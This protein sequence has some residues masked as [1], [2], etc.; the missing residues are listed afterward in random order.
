MDPAFDPH[1]GE[2]IPG[3]TPSEHGS[4]PDH[5]D[6]YATALYVSGIDPKGKGRNERGP[7]TYIK[8]A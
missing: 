3:R 4:I 5:G 2:A 7:L 6:I 8:R 1:T